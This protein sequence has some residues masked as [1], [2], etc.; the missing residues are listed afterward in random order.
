MSRCTE[1]PFNKL[2]PLVVAMG[3]SPRLASYHV[4]CNAGNSGNAVQKSFVEVAVNMQRSISSS[5]EGEKLLAGLF[6]R[7][8]S[9]EKL[10]KAEN[11]QIQIS[12]PHIFLIS[13]GC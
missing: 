1:E 12:F 8:E 9:C 7:L 5:K 2:K 13:H 3:E 11:L 4:K 6:L 10:A